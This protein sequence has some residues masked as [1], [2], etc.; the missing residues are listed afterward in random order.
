[1]CVC[2]LVGDQR[3]GPRCEW[4]CDIGSYWVVAKT[5][6]GSRCDAMMSSTMLS[7]HMASRLAVCVCVCD[8]DR[9]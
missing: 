1:M 4:M 2:V 9:N 7:A 3:S 8:V 6:R 5:S